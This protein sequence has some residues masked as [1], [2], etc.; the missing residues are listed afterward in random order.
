MR[1]YKRYCGSVV[2][3]RRNNVGLKWSWN[4]P[5]LS[6]DFRANWRGDGVL[7]ELCSLFKA[8]ADWPYMGVRHQSQ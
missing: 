6:V 2:V 5:R 4:S 8:N 1:S 3:V 7:S